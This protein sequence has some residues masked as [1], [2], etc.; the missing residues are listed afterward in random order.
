MG[1]SGSQLPGNRCGQ[2]P[3]KPAKEVWLTGTADSCGPA[4]WQRH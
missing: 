2:K 4:P 3:A 1:P